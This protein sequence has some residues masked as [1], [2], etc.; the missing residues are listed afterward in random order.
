MDCPHCNTPQSGQA[1][2][3]RNCGQPLAEAPTRPCP[4]C[5][6]PNP[7]EAR[8]CK[9]C[10]AGLTAAAA[11]D[12][13]TEPDAEQEF[14]LA[15]ASA[16]GHKPT[17][18]RL[19]L[20]MGVVLVA[21]AV[22]GAAV[23]FFAFREKPEAIAAPPALQSDAPAEPPREEIAPPP[24]EEIAPS[25]EV[26]PEPESEAPP[27]PSAAEL[28]KARET[29]REKARAAAREKAAREAEER[30]ARA[31]QEAPPA[32]RTC[33]EASGF[34]ILICQTEG[35]ERFWRCAPDGVNWDND[36]P[37]CKRDTGRNSMTPY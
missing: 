23:W 7:P 19:A 3:C 22:L 29:E 15:S 32:P 26:S 10:G 31:E 34:S 28:E 11:A 20:M 2:F 1:R 4:F 13:A 37:G 14:L 24:R 8:F 17:S 30:A 18:T 6:A 5:Q 21:L 9:G 25:E 36:I 16:T 27:E 12:A 35:P 33:S